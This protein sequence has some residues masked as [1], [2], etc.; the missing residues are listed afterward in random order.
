MFKLT[1]YPHSEDIGR[2]LFNETKNSIVNDSYVSGHDNVNVFGHTSLKYFIKTEVP[3][4]EGVKVVG[5]ID[6]SQF[7][8]YKKEQNIGRN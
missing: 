5:K 3:F 7:E 1:H 2:I 8:K 6:L 4:I